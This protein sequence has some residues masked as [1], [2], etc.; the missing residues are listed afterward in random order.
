VTS[1]TQS[2]QVIKLPQDKLAQLVVGYRSA[3]DLLTDLDMQA[4]GDTRPLLDTLF[5]KCQPHV[6]MPDYF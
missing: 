6:W 3:S 2:D 5:P 4:L 1:G